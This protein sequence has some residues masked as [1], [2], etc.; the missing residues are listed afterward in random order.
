MATRWKLGEFSPGTLADVDKAS[1]VSRAAR[2]TLAAFVADAAA[3]WGRGTVRTTAPRGQDQGHRHHGREDDR[4][5]G[6]SGL[7]RPTDGQNQ[8]RH[9]SGGGQEQPRPHDGAAEA[10][11]IGADDGPQPES[12]GVHHQREGADRRHLADEGE[13][14][15]GDL[16]EGDNE[17]GAF[18]TPAQVGRGGHH[19][20][21]G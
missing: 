21:G 15:D 13:D 11:A 17:E 12:G 8:S 7:R 4:G 1:A 5:R 2:L 20:E 18:E 9:Q 14:A 6:P 3:T 10:A 16:T 19:Q